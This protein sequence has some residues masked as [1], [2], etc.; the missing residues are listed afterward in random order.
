MWWYGYFY[1]TSSDQWCRDSGNK[2]HEGPVNINYQLS[3]Q[4]LLSNRK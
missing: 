4:A 1:G 3:V 2:K